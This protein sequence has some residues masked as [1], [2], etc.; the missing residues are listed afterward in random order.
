MNNTRRTVIKTTSAFG[1]L[2]ALGLVTQQQAMAAV[3]RASFDVKTLADAFKALGGAPTASDKVSVIAPDIAENGAVV[4]VG[5][6]S[7]LPNTTEMFLIVEK[8]PTPLA[9]GFEIPAGT[10]ASVQTRLKM[11]Q[12]TD[13]YA[14]VKA[15]GKLYMAKKETKVTLGGC[16][17]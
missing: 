9:V 3:D 4:P 14:V 17:G 16:G 13:V 7:S 12:S 15:D 2:I 5:A 11:G 8:N 1:S 6:S 10:E